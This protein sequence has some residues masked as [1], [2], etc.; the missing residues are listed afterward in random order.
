[1]Y[2]HVIFNADNSEDTAVFIKLT[3]LNGL[4]Y[5][6]FSKSPELEQLLG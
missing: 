6:R 1:M 5:Q 3:I 2:A 4:I